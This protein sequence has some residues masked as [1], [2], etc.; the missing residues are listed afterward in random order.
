MPL[1][2][3][4]HYIVVNEGK[5]FDTAGLPC[6]PD[7]A[8]GKPD[9][10]AYFHVSEKYFERAGAMCLR[11]EARQVS[12]PLLRSRVGQPVYLSQSVPGWSNDVVSVKLEPEMDKGQLRVLA[13]FTDGN[14]FPKKFGAGGWVTSTSSVVKA[15]EYLLLTVRPPEKKELLVFLRLRRDSNPNSR[16]IGR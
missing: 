14:P 15:D 10:R 7:L 6:L 4:A 5:S 1:V 3:S 2:V 8:P 9:V 13:T 16:T 11:T 12:A